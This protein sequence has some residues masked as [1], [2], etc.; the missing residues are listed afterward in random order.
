MSQKKQDRINAYNYI[1][2]KIREAGY[3]Q[4][5]RSY[6]K[7]NDYYLSLDDLD[8]LRNGLSDPDEQLVL[9]LKQLLKQVASEVEIDKNLVKPFQ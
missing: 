1:L 8:K 5:D 2:K 7:T 4:Y 3:F 9:T 6:P